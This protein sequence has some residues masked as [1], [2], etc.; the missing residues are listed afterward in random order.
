MNS[1]KT[2]L[3]ALTGIRAFCAYCI[4]VYH[5]HPLIPE[6]DPVIRSILNQLD[7]FISFF[8]VISG[9]IITHNYYETGSLNKRV[10]YNYAV[11]RFARIFPILFILVTATFGIALIKH[12][13]SPENIVTLYLLNISFIK[14]FSRE[15][16]LSGIGPS[17]TL[18][19]DVIFYILAPFIFYWC[20]SAKRLSIFTLFTL[21]TGIAITGIIGGKTHAGYFNDLPFTLYF[22]FFGR[23]FEFACGIYLALVIRKKIA[24]QWLNKIGSASTYLGLSIVILAIAGLTFTANY[25]QT[26]K[27]NET[28][29]GI[30]INNFVM[31]AGAILLFYGLINFPS[32]I[33]KIFGNRLAVEL[34]NSTYSFYLLH[35]T[36]VLSWIFKYISHNIA[37]AFFTM[38][39]FSYLFYRTIEQPID[40]LIKARWS[41]K[42]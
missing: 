34:G 30:A 18:S 15:Y 40:K 27:A 19:V 32:V 9:F 12:Y 5:I 2:F 41:K 21:I 25:Y 6:I 4:F 24:G 28:L 36:F 31:P 20:T 38:I 22:T 23:V 3:P 17:W 29:I 33:Q 26:A 11:N 8:F 13:D 39:I 16:I 7:T 1:S 35:T 42:I 10:L 37:I 14:G